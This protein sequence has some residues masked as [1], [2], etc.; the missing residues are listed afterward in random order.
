MG[1]ISDALATTTVPTRHRAVIAALGGLVCGAVTL[2][3]SLS[4]DYPRDFG[5][6]WF[7]ARMLLHGTN[8]YPLVG[9]HLAYDWAYP[10]LYPLTAGAIALP[11]APLSM[12]VADLLF[13]AL[14]GAAFA[15]AL[16]EYG[17]GPLFGFFGASLH[18]AAET[19]QWSPLFAAAVVVPSL[20]IFLVAKP[21]VALATFAARP[22]WWAVI[23]AVVFG[24][25]AL[26]IVPTWPRDWIDAVARDIAEWGPYR[27]YRVP[28]LFPGGVLTLLC[29]ARWRRPEARLVAVLACVPQT[30]LLYETVPLFMVPRT[31]WQAATLVGL[32]YASHHLSVW[33]APLVQV[34]RFEISGQ[35]AVLL[36]YLPCTL[37]VLRRPNE[38]AVP[39]WLEQRIGA[40]PAWLR[41]QALPT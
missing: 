22:S 10:L 41:G 33:I 4:A 23:G 16:M 26:A 30:P 37:M 39:A 1:W 11:F 24:G 5:Q 21:T 35:L 31:F 13:S 28:L 32:S 40:W 38:G 3:K 14:V 25:I 36:L 27:P 20:S 12:T 15:W 17:Y 19:V 2:Q 7:A 8:P 34:E 9:P 18:F 6:V 29:L